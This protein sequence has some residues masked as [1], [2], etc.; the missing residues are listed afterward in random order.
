M[1][2]F[3][4]IKRTENLPG[5]VIIRIGNEHLAMYFIGQEPGEDEPGRRAFAVNLLSPTEG[6][7][8]VAETMRLGQEEVSVMEAGDA[9]YTPLWPWAL[10]A[11]LGLLM[12]EWWVFH[13]KSLI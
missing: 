8:A 1:P 6:D 12:L 10:G 3:L 5:P 11:C 13:R 7:V 2:H 9:A 4:V